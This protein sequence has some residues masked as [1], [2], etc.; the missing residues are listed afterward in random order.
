MAYF[1]THSKQQIT[2][3]SSGKNYCEL[4]S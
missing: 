4:K 2:I 1:K 3:S